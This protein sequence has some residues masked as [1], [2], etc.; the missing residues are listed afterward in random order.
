[1]MMMMAILALAAQ[2]T[3]VSP[4]LLTLAEARG[5]AGDTLTAC[6]ARKETVAVYVT[7]AEGHM[8]AALSADGLNVV[9]LTSVTRKTAAV[10]EFHQSTRAL[11]ARLESDPAFRDGAG[12]DPRFFFHAG[13]L[14][15]YRG[16]VFV[17]VLAAGGGH[18]Q[19][20]ACALEAV[21]H[22]AALSVKP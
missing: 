6:A 12:K 3:L 20:E 8:R 11:G 22:Q 14:P 2:G 13:A 16:G 10:L 1:M 7:D 17:G 19:D 5:L 15:L 9:G 21:S 4:A 18:D